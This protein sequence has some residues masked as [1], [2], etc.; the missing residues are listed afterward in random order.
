MV[1]GLWI[2]EVRFANTVFLEPIDSI[3]NI[4]SA[5]W[6]LPCRV[7][8]PKG[9]VGAC[10]QCHKNS[11][12][13][14]FHVTCG[15]LAGLHMKMETVHESGPGGTSITVRKSA[16]CEQH[17]P[18]DSDAKP[19]LDDVAALGI[20]T[21]KYKKSPKKSVDDHHPLPIL[22]RGLMNFSPQCPWDKVQKIASLV[23]IQKKSHFIQRLMAYWTL[24][25]QTRNGVPLIR[26]LQF[27][28]ATK[29]DKL[30][31][32]PQK[33][34]HHAIM[35]D[36][37]ASIKEL[38]SETDTDHKEKTKHKKEKKLE[39]TPR[40]MSAAEKA[41]EQFKTM[42]EE[43]RKM[44]RLRQDL[45]RVRLLCEL[46]RKREQRKRELVAASADIKFLE[47]NPFSFFL[48]KILDILTEQDTTEIFR[49]PVDP[50]EVPDYLDL[51]KKPM[52]FSTMRDKVE[53]FKY[54][55]F[56]EFESDFN[57]MV[58][59]C[60][61]YNEKETIFY[62]AGTKMRDTGGS[63]L[64]QLRRQ[65]EQIKQMGL[66]Q[67][68]SVNQ[69][70]E[71]LSDLKLMKEIDSFINEEDRDALSN[72][73]HLQ[74]LL[75][76]SD[77]AQRIHHPVAK[78]KRIQI[79]LS[80][81]R[82]L[83]RKISLD[84][85]EGKTEVDKSKKNTPGGRGRKRQRSSE[86]EKEEVKV[87]EEEEEEKKSGKAVVGV[88]RRNAVLFTRKKAA[89]EEKEDKITKRNDRSV[90]PEEAG[91]PGAK[92]PDGG[93]KF[94]FNEPSTPTETG[95]RGRKTR[96]GKEL[97]KSI[98]EAKAEKFM[99]GPKMDD[100]M[101]QT[102]RGS[103]G[104]D[105][106]TDTGAESTNDLNTTDDDDSSS[107]SGDDSYCGVAALDIPLE[108]LDLVWAKC[109]GYPWY[110]A[111]IIN[112]KMPRTGYFHN[113][114][115]IP[116]PPIEVLNLAETHTKPHYLILF[117][118]TKRT[119]QWLP[120]DKLEPLG[121]DTDLDKTKLTESRKASE[122]KAVKKAYEEAILHRCRVTG[123]SIDLKTC[124]TKEQDSE[125]KEE[126]EEKTTEKLKKKK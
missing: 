61:A 54:E 88:N 66:E 122:K 125:E 2:P 5:R 107:D 77:N 49:E 105:T 119:W 21:S 79:L 72:E 37:K 33:N 92:K 56:D 118:D 62:R 41:G 60:L 53:D 102:Y 71:E 126:E 16:F 99:G 19:R 50:D 18:A 42:S 103:G 34:S 109:R 58:S 63:I 3:A 57:L 29:S 75:V 95:Y 59:N 74:K 44:R 30:V 87:E 80:E 48:R 6:K 64:R 82:K 108:P 45:E 90:E 22:F 39:M 101:F 121:V 52:D 113:G 84:K 117:F 69:D 25:R 9:T 4:P 38:D 20:V 93:D 116:V 100:E 17:T 89:T 91:T 94:E 106:D 35:A 110:P 10:I 1:C 76:C 123:E 65:A 36:S 15:L 23:D 115:P 104:V 112:P 14:A 55:T 7:C 83:R 120:R 24:K 96:K 67:N 124:Q 51:I 73:D 32:T 78:K 26:R 28:K 47:L 40:P 31:E 11:C 85:K 46:I 97:E 70:Q 86:N 114:V 81:I 27:A 43:R 13:A 8:R 98:L 12:F 111:L 68:S